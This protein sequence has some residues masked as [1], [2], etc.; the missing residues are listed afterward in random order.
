[1][2]IK[3]FKVFL[4]SCHRLSEMNTVRQRVPES[5]SKYT[6]RA[7]A[8]PEVGT[9]NLKTFGCVKNAIGSFPIF[10]LFCHWQF[11]SGG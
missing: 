9:W 8:K 1:M 6:E 2:K 3:S 4:E 7:Q 11:L 5:G 10:S